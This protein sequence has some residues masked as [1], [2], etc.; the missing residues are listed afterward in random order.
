MD[1]AGTALLIPTSCKA[2]RLAKQ[3]SELVASNRSSIEAVGVRVRVAAVLAWRQS[4]GY[5]MHPVVLPCGVPLL[6][7]QQQAG[8][9]AFNTPADGNFG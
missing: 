5:L 4:R 7:S 2:A 3:C 9:P 8:M 1:S 6:V